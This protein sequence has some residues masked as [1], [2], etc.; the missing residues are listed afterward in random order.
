M[1]AQ[2]FSY[3]SPDSGL[4]KPMS[5]VW[6]PEAQLQFQWVRPDGVVQMFPA[7]HP[8]TP[9]GFSSLVFESEGYLPAE[10]IQEANWYLA[11]REHQR[12]QAKILRYARNRITGAARGS[13]SRLQHAANKFLRE[14]SVK[15]GRKMR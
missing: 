11:S 9:D 15:T 3:C 13:E 12:E 14:P 6:V 5:V 10:M 2:W 4:P 1:K 7:P 8:I